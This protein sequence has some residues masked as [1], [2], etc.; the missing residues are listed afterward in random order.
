MASHACLPSL[1]G[2]RNLATPSSSS[3]RTPPLS[4]RTRNVTTRAQVQVKADLSA[5]STSEAL[6]SMK[7]VGGEGTHDVSRKST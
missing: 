2:V 1:T 5:V 7:I 6:K 3:R 4:L